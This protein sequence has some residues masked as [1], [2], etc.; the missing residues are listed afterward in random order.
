MGHPHTMSTVGVDVLGNRLGKRSE[1][2]GLCLSIIP[3][4]II[5]PRKVGYD[6]VRCS[7]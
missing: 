5:S 4:A 3:Q 2:E 7:F 1:C 6:M